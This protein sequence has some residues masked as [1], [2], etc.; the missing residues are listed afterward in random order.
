MSPKFKRAQNVAQ[1][2]WKSPKCCQKLFEECKSVS[3]K[4][5]NWMKLLISFSV[6]FICQRALGS[7]HFPRRILTNRLKGIERRS[8]LHL[9]A[10]FVHVQPSDRAGN[11]KGGRIT[12]PL[13]SCLTGWD[14][15][16]I[17]KNCQFSYS[18]FHTSQTGGQSYSDTPPFSIPWTEYQFQVGLWPSL[19]SVANVINLFT[20]VSYT[21]S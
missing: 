5:P 12:V 1:K 21:F 2:I 7:D 4:L 18:W 8:V 11:A 14:S 16:V 20:A 13:T 15:P 19:C 3:T 10:E 17:Q 9:A 6:F